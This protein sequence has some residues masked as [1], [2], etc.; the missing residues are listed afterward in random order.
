[1]GAGDAFLTAFLLSLAGQGWKKGCQMTE[2]S[3]KKALEN[4]ARYVAENCMLKG[5]L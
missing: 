2:Q 3:L 1:M 5:G 4:G